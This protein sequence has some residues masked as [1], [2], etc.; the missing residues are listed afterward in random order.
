[1][2]ADRSFLLA[3]KALTPDGWRLETPTVL[4][5]LEKLRRAGTP[6]GEYVQG[7]FYRGIITGLNEAFVVDRA[8]RDRLIREHKSSETV[9]KPFLRG[10]DVKR[11]RI[12][13][14]DLYLCYVPWDMSMSSY[15]AIYNHVRRFESQ[16][17][18]RP[19]VKQG[20]FPWYALSRYAAKYWQEFNY[21]QIV[22]GNLATQPQFAFS[23]Q[24]TY[25]N[26]PACT[27]ISDSKY[28]LAILNSSI[29]KYLVAQSAA[30]RQGGFLEFKP[31][32]VSQIPIPTA[33]PEQQ[34]AIAALVER[35]LA[36]KQANA[37]A[38]VS[39]LEGEIDALVYRLYG[40]TDE[41]VQVVAGV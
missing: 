36:A 24:G 28:L 27:I 31:M 1:V 14:P 9:L 35:I 40:L 25:L 41:E 18:A 2:F 33:T 30:E 7:R 10:R 11:W 15:P 29:S 22:W 16:L 34:A 38:D 13:Q 26:A 6:L 8:T 23:S 21:A 19:E 17:K 12:N 37:G 32:Y 39:V 4:R 20:R 5:L 3:Q